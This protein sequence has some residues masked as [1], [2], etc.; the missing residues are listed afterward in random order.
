VSV[1]ETFLKIA[2]SE[3]KDILFFPCDMNYGWFME[4]TLV[5]W[6][7]EG[8]PDGDVCEYFGFERARFIPGDPYALY[9]PFEERILRNEGDTLIVREGTG[10]T[11]RVFQASAE[12]KMPQ[13]LDFPV[14]TRKDWKSFVKRLDPHSQERYVCE[15]DSTPLSERPYLLGI[16]AGSFYGHTLQRW[17]GTENLCMLFYDDPGFVQEML[18]YLEYFF[19]QIAGRILAGNTFDFAAFGE[20]IAYKGRSFVSPGMFKRFFQSRSV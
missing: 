5:R 17:V 13:W 19:L 16:A 14:K 12:S 4:E 10:V 7:K 20:D 2:R 15:S 9:P 11:K 1:R 3:L 18:E 8:M 6:K